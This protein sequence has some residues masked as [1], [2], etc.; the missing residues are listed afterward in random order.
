MLSSN[1]VKIWSMLALSSLKVVVYMF[2]LIEIFFSLIDFII[3]LASFFV[4][5]QICL[6][7]KI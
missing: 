5:P 6:V 7:S 3:I 2:I 4:F 1:L